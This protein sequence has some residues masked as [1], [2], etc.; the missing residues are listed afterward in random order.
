[1]H[2]E[3]KLSRS[4]TNELKFLGV[5]YFTVNVGMLMESHFRPLESELPFP[6]Q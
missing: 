2:S 6:A 4:D 1:M 3:L 5:S